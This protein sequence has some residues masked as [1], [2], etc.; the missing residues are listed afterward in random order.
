MSNVQAQIDALKKEID[1][2]KKEINSQKKEIIALQSTTK[3]L[4]TAHDHVLLRQVLFSAEKRLLRFYL[5]SPDEDWFD[6][7]KITCFHDLH[8]W[9]RNNSNTLIRSALSEA[10]DAA[11]KFA[12]EEV[13]ARVREAGN[14][15]AH[16]V[17]QVRDLDR[18][19]LNAIVKRSFPTNL[20]GKDGRAGYEITAADAQAVVDLFF[21]PLNRVA[22][23][24]QHKKVASKRKQL[25]PKAQKKGQQSKSSKQEQVLRRVFFVK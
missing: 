3:E 24:A 14:F 21:M 4:Q 2:Q 10:R 12:S 15:S 20:P 13:R 16:P 1:S 7:R 22:S 5:K 6:I 18:A 17:A 11:D 19:K 9:L 23:R 8:L 25:G